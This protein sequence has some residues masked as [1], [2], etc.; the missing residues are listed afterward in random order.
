MAHETIYEVKT[1]QGTVVGKAKTRKGARRVLD[2][3]DAS[4]GASRHHI[5][6]RKVS[7]PRKLGT[8]GAVSPPGLMEDVKKPRGLG[9]RVVKRKT[10][11]R[12]TVA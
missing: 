9:K 4:Y 8:S 1:P 2:R 6:E 3:R 12:K 10:R 11:K 7:K 5:S